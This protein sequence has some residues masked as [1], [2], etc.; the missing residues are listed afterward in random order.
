M[1]DVLTK[2]QICMGCFVQSGRLCMMFCRSGKAMCDV[3]QV[4]KICMMFYP[5]GRDVYD[6]MSKWQKCVCCLPG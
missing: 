3:R 2:W 4:V 6:A 1:C 5:S